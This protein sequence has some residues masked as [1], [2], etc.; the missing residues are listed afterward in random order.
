MHSE[1]LHTKTASCWQRIAPPV[2]VDEERRQDAD[3]RGLALLPLFP[4]GSL[5]SLRHV[6]SP[7]LSCSLLLRLRWEVPKEQ[8]WSVWCRSPPAFC[9]C[10]F[11]LAVI[12]HGRN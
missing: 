11:R 2:V 9:L 3:V 4:L 5:H 10:G 8:R 7:N 1:T 6:V 12:Y